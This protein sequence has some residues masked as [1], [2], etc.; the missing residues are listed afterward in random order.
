[1]IVEDENGRDIDLRDLADER[2]PEP[3]DPED[4]MLMLEEIE[5]LLEQTTGALNPAGHQVLNFAVPQLL[6]RVRLLEA[7]LAD[8]RQRRN[9]CTHVH[10]YVIT[11]GRPDDSTSRVTVQQADHAHDHPEG[12]KPWART[13]STTPW[14]PHT[15]PPF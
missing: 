10:E 13:I 7:T 12:G 9:S 8:E 5:A 15:P 2:E 11:H 6:A 4:E 1:M 3:P 14:E